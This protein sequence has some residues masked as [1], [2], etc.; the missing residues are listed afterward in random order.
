MFMI[1]IVWDI[2]TKKKEERTKTPNLVVDH[3]F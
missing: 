3:F 1:V 2:G